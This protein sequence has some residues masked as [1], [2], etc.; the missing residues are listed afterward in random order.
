MMSVIA[1][2]G[3]KWIL[4]FWELDRLAMKIDVRNKIDGMIIQQ[5]RSIVGSMTRIN[6]VI[7][8]RLL[9]RHD[10]NDDDELKKLVVPT[11]MSP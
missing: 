3:R 4:I 1:S 5:S 7:R 10:H 9:K 11:M 6:W 2:L 8:P